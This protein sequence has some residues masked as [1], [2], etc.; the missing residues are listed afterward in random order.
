VSQGVSGCL[1]V[2]R[3]TGETG[4]SEVVSPWKGGE[5]ET[6]RSTLPL[7]APEIET[8]QTTITITTHLQ[9]PE[10]SSEIEK[11][12]IN[13]VA[14]T[15]W[16]PKDPPSTFVVFGWFREKE[17]ELGRAGSNRLDLASWPGSRPQPAV[18]RAWYQSP[19]K[20]TFEPVCL[21]PGQK[22]PLTL[23]F[24][25]A[26]I[27]TAPRA[28]G[29][30]GDGKNNRGSV[31][32]RRWL[33]F[34]NREPAPG[35]KVILGGDPFRSEVSAPCQPDRPASGAGRLRMPNS[36]AAQGENRNAKHPA[37]TQPAKAPDQV[38]A[39]VL[40]LC[41]IGRQGHIKP[42]SPSL[43]SNAEHSAQQFARTGESA[44]AES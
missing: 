4:V 20:R 30:Q 32:G 29:L 26:G 7:S 28:T 9:R 34:R 41:G 2:S 22:R 13:V 12:H 36:P 39:H 5:T 15:G 10:L 43:R 1:R 44:R 17:G 33:V 14:S 18:A 16:P 11:L 23:P 38:L 24:D 19:K 31:S 25:L 3:E 6:L 42:R 27:N 8:L 40:Q 35:F 37:G 21:E